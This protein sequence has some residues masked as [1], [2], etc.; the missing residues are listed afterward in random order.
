MKEATQMIKI[1]IFDENSDQI[2][3][4]ILLVQQQTPS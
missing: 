1:V 2:G 4:K 3:T